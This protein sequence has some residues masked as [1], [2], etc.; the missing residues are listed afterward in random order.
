[1]GFYSRGNTGSNSRNLYTNSNKTPNSISFN[2]FSDDGAALLD[3]KSAPLLWAVNVCKGIYVIIFHCKIVIIKIMT[4][5]FTGLRGTI[6]NEEGVPPNI[7]AEVGREL[8]K[9]HFEVQ[10]Y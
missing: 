2:S 1:M 9:A 3:V 7:T 6:V 10:F 4:A 8:A 5:H